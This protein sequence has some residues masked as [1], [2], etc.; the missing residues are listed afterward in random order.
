MAW[1]STPRNAAKSR[2][3]L[4]EMHLPSTPP[5][6][7]C[8]RRF[9]IPRCRRDHPTNLGSRHAPGSRARYVIPEKRMGLVSPRLP[10]LWNVRS[11]SG[12]HGIPPKVA[13]AWPADYDARQNSDQASTLRRWV[14]CAYEIQLLCMTRPPCWTRPRVVRSR[15]PALPRPCGIQGCVLAAGP[16]IHRA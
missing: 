6:P 1:P 3:T 16:P 2:V 13:W 9:G 12:C 15:Q 4:A 14:V 8:A 11:G 7:D 5:S 10:K